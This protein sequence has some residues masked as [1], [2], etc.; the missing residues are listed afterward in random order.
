MMSDFALN[1]KKE[2]RVY[3]KRTTLYQ[4]HQFNIEKPAFYKEEVNYIDNDVYN[5]SNEFWDENR[6]ENLNKM[7]VGFIKC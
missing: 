6:F 2:S 5:K 3:G 7:N 1:K 4:N